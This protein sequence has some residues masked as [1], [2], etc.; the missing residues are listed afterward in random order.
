MSKQHAAIQRVPTFCV[1]LKPLSSAQ[2]L[3]L[4]V[5]CIWYNGQTQ[6]QQADNTSQHPGGIDAKADTDTSFAHL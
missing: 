6:T 3:L 2:M 4:P 5:C 1:I